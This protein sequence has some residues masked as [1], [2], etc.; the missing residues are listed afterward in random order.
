MSVIVPSYQRRD[1]L[2]R[3]LGT[4]DEATGRNADVE[5]VVILDGSTDGSR[6]ALEKARFTFPLRWQ[7]QP[8]R[9]RS[10]ARNAGLALAEA[11]VCWLVDDDMTIDREAF[12]THAEFHRNAPEPSVLVGPQVENRGDRYL[13]HILQERIERLARDRVVADP[14]DFWT[15]NVSA[16]RQTLLEVGGFSED[17][18]GWGEED[19]ELGFRIMKAGVPVAYER[20]AGGHHWRKRPLSHRIIEERERGR[21]IVRL[22]ELH[23][24]A[25]SRIFPSSTVIADLHRRNLRSPLVYGTIGRSAA[26]ALRS[27]RVRSSGQS[28]RIFN[29]GM[30]ASRLA[31]IIEEGGSER[32]Q[33]R[34]TVSHRL[35]RSPSVTA[36]TE[37]RPAAMGTND[38]RSEYESTGLVRQSMPLADQG[39]LDR[40]RAD[41]PWFANAVAELREQGFRRVPYAFTPAIEQVATDPGLTGVIEEILGD[42]RWVAW[43]A[44]IQIGTPNAAYEWHTDIESDHWPTITVAIG[45]SGCREENAT[46]YLPGSHLFPVTPQACGDPT[47]DELVLATARVLDPRTQEIV[48]FEGFGDGRFTI[49]DAKGWH[50]GDAEPSTDRLA[51]FLHYQRADDHRIP[52]M[53]DFTTNSWFE[54]AAAFVPNPRLGDDVERAVYPPPYQPEDA[55]R[56]PMRLLRTTTHSLRRGRSRAARA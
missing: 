32:L 47:D 11:E 31:G 17:F 16:H 28:D 5:V 38:V 56:L 7:W 19:I 24:E 25:T 46:R 20:A 4:L 29:I 23:P 42:E 18:V 22:C 41:A 27:E 48:R 26:L 44:N 9:G 49:F 30:S 14:F 37:S 13:D 54:E 3:L 8:N 33:R 51:L 10:A 6:E 50:C 36:E 45:L 55:A 43:G 1:S 2:L 34:A 15:G 21:N 12:E 52:Y 40:L 53:R 39:V 35:F